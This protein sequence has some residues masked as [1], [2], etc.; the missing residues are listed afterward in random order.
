MFLTE[1]SGARWRATPTEFRHF[2]FPYFKLKNIKDF[3]NF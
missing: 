2:L 1:L 3:V